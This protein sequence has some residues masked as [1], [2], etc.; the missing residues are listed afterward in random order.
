MNKVLAIFGLVLFFASSAMAQQRYFDERYI[1]THHFINPALINPA[2]TGVADDKFIY[3]NYRNKWASF[4]ESPKTM[5]FGYSGNLADRLGIG[6]MIINDSNAGLQT[7][8]GQLSLSYTIDSPTNKVGFGIS[9]EFIQHKV[10]GEVL[11]N[12]LLNLNDEFI[13]SRLDGN[14]FFDVSFGVYG[15][16]DNRFTYG[17]AIPSLVSSQLTDENADSGERELG[18]ILNLGYIHAFEEHDIIAEPSIIYKNLMFVPT[19]VDVNLKLQFLQK[20]FTGGLTY[21]IGA[22]ERFGVLLG[23]RVNNLNF[24]YSYNVSRHEFQSYNNG[25]HEISIMVN[26]GTNNSSKAEMEKELMMKEM[27]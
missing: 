6:G 8:K 27:N 15:V 25:S 2:Y 22:D 10:S 3:F 19:V 16:Y 7:T 17:L 18:Y 20:K 4:P 1:Y 21:G 26:L 5:T 14:N 9:T 23:M 24:F 13:L 11:N 12:P